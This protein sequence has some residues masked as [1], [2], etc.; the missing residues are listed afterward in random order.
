M[1]VAWQNCSGIQR[2]KLT[3]ICFNAYFLILK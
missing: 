3:I 1:C 2:S